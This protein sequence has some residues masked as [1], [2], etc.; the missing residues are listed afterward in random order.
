MEKKCGYQIVGIG[1]GGE[2]V[3]CVSCRAS[4]VCLRKLVWG[5]GD[6]KGLG[7]AGAYDSCGGSPAVNH[8]VEGD[9]GTSMESLVFEPIEKLNEGAQTLTALAE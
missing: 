9:C 8:L 5:K 3:G 4:K 7:V 6:E 2:R 1:P